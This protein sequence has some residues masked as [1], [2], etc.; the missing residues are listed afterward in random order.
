MDMDPLA[1][2]TQPPWIIAH[3]GVSQL[4]PE[5]THLAF[6]AALR[7]PIAGME[8]DLQLSRDG[9]PVVWHHRTLSRAGLR[10]KRVHLLDFAT[11]RELDVTAWLHARFGSQSIPTLDEVLDRYGGRTRLFLEVKAR[12]GI[13]T[14][15]RHRELAIRVVE[16]VASRGLWESVYILSF[17][18]AVLTATR[19]VA[20]ALR[21]V[22]NAKW[23]V[24]ITG[25]RGVAGTGLTGVCIDIRRL[26]PAYVARCHAVGLAVLTYG[27][28]SQRVV[29]RGVEAQVDGM[30]SNHPFWL[31]RYLDEQ[32]GTP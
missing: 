5:N 30:I 2:G 14:G 4:L 22:L 9:V 10:G 3:R 32:K 24:A 12:K 16:A 8:L 28:N 6:E 7:A 23:P 17:N 25:R 20:P 27:C 13:D 11:L 21:Y 19:K 31:A 15:R 1:P 26:S 29:R 18:R